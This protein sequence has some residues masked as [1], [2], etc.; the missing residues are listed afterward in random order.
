MFIQMSG[1][2][3]LAKVITKDDEIISL[4]E[5]QDPQRRITRKCLNITRRGLERPEVNLSS[6]IAGLLIESRNTSTSKNLSDKK[7][8]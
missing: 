6:E 4:P 7:V 5:R 2:L 3:F 8:D 1:I